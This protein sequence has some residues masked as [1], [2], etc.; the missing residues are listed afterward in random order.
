[1]ALGSLLSWVS[2]GGAERSSVRCRQSIRLTPQHTLH[3]VEFAERQM[4]VA[5]HP[6]GTN[7][8]STGPACN[9]KEQHEQ[10]ATD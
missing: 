3:V 5:C 7:V 1:M 2:R 10:P 4:L 8:L 6:G 9:P